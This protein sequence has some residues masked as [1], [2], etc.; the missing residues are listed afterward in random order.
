MT[1]KDDNFS[2]TL[3][4]ALLVATS[5]AF[6]K[7]EIQKLREEFQYLKEKDKIVE[8]VEIKG[9]AGPRGPIGPVG[10]SGERGLK[11]DTGERG[12]KGEVGPQGNLGQTGPRGLKGDKGDKGEV[13]PQGIQ[14]ERG[15]QGLKGD[16]GDDG[17][18]GLDG[19]DGETGAMGPVGPAGEQGLQPQVVRERGRRLH[20]VGFRARKLLP[21]EARERGRGPQQFRT[22]RSRNLHSNIG[23]QKIFAGRPFRAETHGENAGISGKILPAF[24]R[25]G[26]QPLVGPGSPR[27]FAEL[28]HHAPLADQ[29]RREIERR[30]AP[31][32]PLGRHRTIV[33]PDEMRVQARP[34]RQGCAGND[35]S[36][37]RNKHGKIM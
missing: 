37:R 23:G 24:A 8:Y 36:G 17:K 4:E 2:D 16:K 9:P 18:N 22:A 11:G 31:A 28:D 26:K 34:L 29:P 6:T 3:N 10:A 12:E 15:L 20:Q 25:R 30:H 5:V 21:H 33:N 14:G 7:R 27:A 13:G 35:R 32:S 1:K 19:R